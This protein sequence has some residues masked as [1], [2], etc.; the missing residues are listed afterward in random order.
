MGA[1]TRV[2]LYF[3]VSYR[4]VAC[5][6]VVPPLAYVVPLLKGNHQQKLRYNIA[7]TVRA[8]VG[9]EACSRCCSILISYVLVLYLFH[10]PSPAPLSFPSSSISPCTQVRSILE[11]LDDAEY[12]GSDHEEREKEKKGGGAKRK[13]T[14]EEELARLVSW[15]ETLNTPTHG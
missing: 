8:G 7:D 15:Q 12:Y 9:S 1:H 4:Y 13:E 14:V 5:V 6:D 3:D 11:D 2:S 10:P